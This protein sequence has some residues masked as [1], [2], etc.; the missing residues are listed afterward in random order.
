MEGKQTL[1]LSNVRRS[2]VFHLRQQKARRTLWHG[3]VIR[4]YTKRV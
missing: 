4:R 2:L 3:G 1:Q